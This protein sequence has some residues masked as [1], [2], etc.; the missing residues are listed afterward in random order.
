VGPQT[1][2]TSFTAD[3]LSGCVP[4][5]VL[6]N[7]ASTNGTS[8]LW[9][10]GD[11]NTS[12]IANP[13]HIY[14]SSGTYTVTLITYNTSACGV[15][16]DS[17]VRTS[18][19]TVYPYAVAAFTPD[20]T[21]GCPPLTI[22]FN[23]T[24]TNANSYLWNFGDGNTGTGNNP[25]HTFTNSGTYTVT[26]IAY[27]TGGC[28]DTLTFQSITVITLPVDSSAFVADT[29][30]GCNPFTVHFTNNSVNGT[31]YHWD[32]GDSTISTSTNPTH[33]FIRSGTFT[34]TLITYNNS[35]C[36]VVTD[37]SVRVSYISVE[38]PVTVNAS[39]S[40]TPINGCA[41]IDVIFTNSSTNATNYF[42]N[43]GDGTSDTSKNPN[44]IFF[45]G[46]TGN[47]VVTLIVTHNSDKCINAPDT[48]TLDINI[49]SCKLYIPNVFSP[50]GDGKNDYY[51]LIAEGYSN[52][53]LVIYDRWG[54]KMFES[55]D[56]NI[57]WNGKI[58]NKG[59]DAPDGTYYY[60]FSANDFTCKS[61]TDKGYL[62]L[63]R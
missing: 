8:Y 40:G 19:I 61:F 48:M 42:W 63:I 21:T 52:Y 12:I 1:V 9:N 57:L 14:L 4:L 34:I 3:T 36:G 15:V 33:T 20:T 55:F 23:N 38:N 46:T 58:N 30:N 44:H 31:S 35:P 7:N 6:F 53:H 56:K 37:T 22:T 10:F 11:G 29:L 43:F 17:L 47:Y 51:F 32:F 50:N 28:N 60:I 13:T 62:T 5:T 24:S 45:Y 2:T 54:L 41:P 16:E 49:D 59:G 18:Y 27:G 25:S 26:L 39:F